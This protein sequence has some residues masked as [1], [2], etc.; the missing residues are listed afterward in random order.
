MSD[1]P[2]LQGLD[3][4]SIPELRDLY[5]NVGE[6]IDEARRSSAYADLAYWLAS[7][8]V[9]EVALDQRLGQELPF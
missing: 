5:M 8:E 7:R 2:E 9:L 6:L 1:H 3:E 4:M